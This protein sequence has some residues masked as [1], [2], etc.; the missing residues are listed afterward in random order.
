MIHQTK[1]DDKML[2]FK[3]AVKA[4]VAG[5]PKVA[6]YVDRFLNGALKEYLAARPQCSF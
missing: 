4:A 1:E 2:P 5:K 3:E 6:A